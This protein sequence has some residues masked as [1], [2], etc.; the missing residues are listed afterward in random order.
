VEPN[1]W[2]GQLLRQAFYLARSDLENSLRELGLTGPRYGVLTHLGW[3][4]GASVAQ[5]SR[6]LVVTPQRMH[7]IVAGLERDGLVARTPH[8]DLERVLRTTLTD[9]GRELL[10]A[11]RE[12]A[13]AAEERLMRGFDDDE[14]EQVRETLRRL[15]DNV[16]SP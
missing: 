16:R 10:N 7:Q 14:R 13:C 6:S 11:S 3:N 2:T 1:V 8:P 4:E 9:A 5:L 12:R 15:I